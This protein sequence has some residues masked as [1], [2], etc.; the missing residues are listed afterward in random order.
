MEQKVADM[1]KNYRLEKDHSK[2]PIK[3]LKKE[4]VKREAANARRR[5]QDFIDRNNYAQT[6]KELHLEK[7]KREFGA[8][9]VEAIQHPEYQSS[10]QSEVLLKESEKYKDKDLWERQKVF[11]DGRQEKLKNLKKEMEDH[12]AIEAIRFQKETNKKALNYRQATPRHIDQSAKTSQTANDSHIKTK[13]R[14]E[15]DVTLH[16]DMPHDTMMIDGYDGVDE[17]VFK[18]VGESTPD[19]KLHSRDHSDYRLTPEHR[20]NIEKSGEIDA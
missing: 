11:M 3:E 6:Q 9:L 18:F 20:D 2:T 17:V 5:V 12:D 1:R 14:P 15:T 8:A 7:L 19:A 13:G 4:R 16:I 10:K